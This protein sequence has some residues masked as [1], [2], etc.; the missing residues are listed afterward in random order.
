MRESLYNKE[1]Y[2]LAL[3]RVNRLDAN[4]APEWGS[5]SS[6]QMFAHCAEV[7]EV[8]NGKALM[9]TPVFLRLLKGM[10]KQA[11]VSKKPYG[12]GVMTH[13]QYKQTAPKAFDA[14]KARLL[15]ALDKFFTEDEASTES[16][17][18]PL[19]GSMNRQEKGW[20]M[21]KH[22]DHHLKQFKV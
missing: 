4:S 1:T 13:P 7:L 9:N 20:A 19:F 15:T 17:P 3:K 14:E 22:L 11:V 6:A 5:M 12:R 8:C 18:H 2:E 21:L 10:I 16:R